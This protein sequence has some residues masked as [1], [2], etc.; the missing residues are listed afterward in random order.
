M[1][2]KAAPQPI[3]S[4]SSLPPELR[5]YIWLLTFEPQTLNISINNLYAKRPTDSPFLGPSA[6]VVF[7]TYRGPPQPFKSLKSIYF[8]EDTEAWKP[9]P[10]GPI[11]LHVCR[12]SRE[13]ALA[14]YELAFGGKRLSDHPDYRVSDLWEQKKLGE[15]KV[16]VDFEGDVIH[17]ANV[18]NL[19]TLTLVASEETRKVQNLV[20][21]TVWEK[22][23]FFQKGAFPSLRNLLTI[24]LGKFESL[25]T[26]S[27]LCKKGIDLEKVRK[28]LLGDF[29]AGKSAEDDLRPEVEVG[30]LP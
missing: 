28:Q 12:E 17:F 3:L 19:N 6:C 15:A 23:A 10:P 13:I 5:H 24:V 8:G 20:I 25:K 11:A 14:R 7:R 29:S 22:G 30:F 27:V 16:W 18:K 26:L 21:N 9:A 1:D 2:S 4:F